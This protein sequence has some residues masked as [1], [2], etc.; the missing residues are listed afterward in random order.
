MSQQFPKRTAKASQKLLAQAQRVQTNAD[1]EAILK[2]QSLRNVKNSLWKVN[3]SDPHKVLTW[4]HMHSYSHG[5]GGKHLWPTIQQHIKGYEREMAKTIDERAASFPSD[6]NKLRDIMKILLYIMHNLLTRSSDCAGHALLK[7]VRIYLNLDMFAAMETHT[8]STIDRIS[9]EISTFSSQIEHLS[10][11]KK[12][13]NFPKMHT[14]TH[15]VEDIIEK[16]VT[17]NGNT[18]VGE[19]FHRPLKHTYTHHSN[20]KNVDE[21]LARYSLYGHAAAIILKR[22][23][24]VDQ[25]NQDEEAE[26]LEQLALQNIDSSVVDYKTHTDYLCSAPQFYR[27]PRHDWVLL[28][29]PEG[30]LTFAQLIFVFTLSTGKA[31]GESPHPFALVLPYS[32]KVT[33]AK[34]T[35]DTDLGLWRIRKSSAT[36]IVAISSIICGALLVPMHEEEEDAIVFDVL[37]TNMFVH[38]RRLSGTLVYFI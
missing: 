35:R 11:F 9:D 13:W 28:D 12:D 26:V 31:P 15:M 21:Q 24:D 19:G 1:A 25:L 16:G 29:D 3:H 33:K 7:A 37:D 30:G 2:T 10:E 20:F 27:Q 38:V 4:D 14:H 32:G 17:Q 8:A 36:K 6:A 5:L 22:M 18:N 34:R 23:H